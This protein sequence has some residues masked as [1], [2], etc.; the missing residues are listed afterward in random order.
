[1][2]RYLAVSPPATSSSFLRLLLSVRYVA[3]VGDAASYSPACFLAWLII[4]SE[5]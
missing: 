1:M 4:A 2:L 5:A 3:S